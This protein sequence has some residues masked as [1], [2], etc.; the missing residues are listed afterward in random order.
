M[1]E[2]AVSEMK[3][4]EHLIDVT[5]KYTRTAEVI[6]NVVKKLID[7]YN[8]AIEDALISAKEKGL[9]EEVPKS[10]K[11]RARELIKLME[12]SEFIMQHISFYF[13]LKNVDKAYYNKEQEFRKNVTLIVPLNEKDQKIVDKIL[14]QYKIDS[15]EKGKDYKGGVNIDVLKIFYAFTG[16]FIKFI[17]SYITGE[18]M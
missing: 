18:P 2:R 1:S 6:K 17:H 10:P 15:L 5:L 11:E 14:N 13:L 3:R 8:V 4:A 9:L 12:R 7:I 16:E